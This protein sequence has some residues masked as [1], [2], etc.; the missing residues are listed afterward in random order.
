MKGS[1]GI[2]VAKVLDMGD[3]VKGD[4]ACKAISGWG[5]GLGLP[6]DAPGKPG[7]P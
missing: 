2:R 3:G 5:E 4:V 1:G 6:G 7:M